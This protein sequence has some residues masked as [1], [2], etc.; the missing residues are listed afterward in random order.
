M[1]LRTAWRATVGYATA[2]L[3]FQGACRSR[4]ATSSSADSQA[5]HVRDVI[6]SGGVVDSIL[7]IAEQLRRFRADIPEQP[8][9]FRRASASVDALVKRWA[10]AVAT[11]DTAALNHLML[12]RAEFAWL[13]YPGSAL[14]K[15]PYESPPQLLWGQIVSNSDKGARQLLARFGGSR[16]DV[17]SVTC[18]APGDSTTNGQ[19]H[20]NC[21]V[22]VR[23]KNGRI[24]EGTLFGSIV[25]HRGRFKFLG[26]AN[27]L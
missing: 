2:L 25:E 22:R 8:D 1:I 20:A 15:P 4:E 3:V 21:R 26:Y 27:R 19:V 17:A 11:Q 6:A 16:F 9:T 5:A 18:P 12:D 13:Y 10:A 14:S 7:P 24:I 23:V